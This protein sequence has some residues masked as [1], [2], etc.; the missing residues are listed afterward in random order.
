MENASSRSPTSGRCIPNIAKPAAAADDLPFEVSCYHPSGLRTR[1]VN[2]DTV[3]RAAHLVLSMAHA[4]SYLLL[5]YPRTPLRR[6]DG[7]AHVYKMRQHL[8]SSIMASHTLHGGRSFRWK[9]THTRRRLG[10]R[11]QRDPSGQC[12]VIEAQM[13]T[14]L[15]TFSSLT[16]RAYTYKSSD[17]DL[18]IVSSSLIL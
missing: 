4:A 8:A 10:D 11:I 6:T 12:C 18:V 2:A 1:D 3:P 9:P 7:C 16:A 15:G 14:T 5:A 13:E 17:I